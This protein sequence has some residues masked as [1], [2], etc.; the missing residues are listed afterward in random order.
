[1]GTLTADELKEEVSSHLGNRTDVTDARLFRYLNLAQMR[2]ARDSK[3]REMQ[4]IESLSIS[5]TGSNDDK[6]IALPSDVR[7]V[8]SL[9]VEDETNSQKLIYLSP[10]LWDKKLPYPEQYTRN[11]PT[12]FTIYR[13]IIELSPMPDEDYTLRLR[14]T[15]W[16]VALTSGGSASELDEKDDL[17]IIL[18]ASM[19]LDTLGKKDEADRKYAIYRNSREAAVRED[20]DQPA[21]ILIPEPLH[22]LVNESVEEYWKDPFYRG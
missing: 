16:P 2:I 12:H 1:M 14:G 17:L 19:L 6:F 11:R 3:Y 9:V 15:K 10:G 8:R 7:S 5:N 20:D 21:E 18:A 4:Y 22:D 13:E